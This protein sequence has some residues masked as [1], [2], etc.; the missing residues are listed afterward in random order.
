ML[1]KIKTK[2]YS[3]LHWSEKY[4]KTD[5]VY[6]VQGGFWLVFGQVISSLSVFLLAIAFA[7]ILPKEIYGIYKYILS[8]AAILGIFSLTGMNTAVSQAVSRGLE[9][10]FKKSFWVQMKWALI[11]FFVSLAFGIYYFIQGNQTLAI[12]FLIIGSFSPLLNSANTYAAFLNGKKDFKKITQY[13]VLSVTFSSLILLF[14]VLITEKPVLLILAYFISNT[15]AN[16]FFYIKTLHVFK[17]N[18]K[19]S[20]ET[21]SY[22]K[23]LSLMNIISIIANYLDSV[24][25]FHFL[26][27]A[28]LAIYSFAIAPPEQIKGLF[29]NIS[30][31]ALPKF[32]ENTKEEIKKTIFRKVIVLGLVITTVV[33]LY[34]MFAPLVYKIFFPKYLESIFYSQIYAI[35]LIAI[36][37][38]LPS[39]A[40]QAQM[41]TKE[42]YF[43]NFW[44]SLIQIILL[45]IFIYFWG[46]LGA[47]ISRILGRFINLIFSLIL[48]KRI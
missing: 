46:I 7:N 17:P 13:N 34:I 26:G 1:A 32:S 2:G 8:M 22:G 38:Y 30:S 10:V 41:A 42:L 18:E 47:V 44:T 35:S 48:L 28:N 15:I 11:M 3:L 37:V 31:L 27:A 40:L 45:I 33:L 29:K 4:L 43:F 6:L 20:E 25:I 14:T 5:M 23:H 36:A 9:G 12:S 16:V 21:I 19:Q 24:L 39:S